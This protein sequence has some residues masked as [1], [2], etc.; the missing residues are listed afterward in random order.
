MKE[1]VIPKAVIDYLE[2]VFPPRDDFPHNAEHTL[3]THHYGQRSVIRFLKSKY[4]Q[5]NDNLLDTD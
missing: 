2:E 3:L 4:K 1:A 5:Q